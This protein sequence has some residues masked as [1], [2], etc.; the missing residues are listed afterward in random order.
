[1]GRNDRPADRADREKAAS[2][3][4]R[5]LIV[6]AAAGTGKT[7]L[8]VE[9]IV[10][11][12][13]AGMAQ[14]EEIVAITFTERA[15]A[16]LRARLQDKLGEEVAEASVSEAE[17]L[18]RA[19]HGLERMQ[20]S[21]IHAF[22]TS[23]LKERPVEAG[24]DPNFGVADELMASL[25]SEDTWDEWI[26]RKM[27]GDDPV[28][29]RTLALGI[30]PDRMLDKMHELAMTISE[31]RDVA[32]LLP[33]VKPSGKCVDDFLKAFKKTA[34]GLAEA[35]RFCR[36]PDDAAL[37]L[38]GDLVKHARDL[39]TIEGDERLHT[40]VFGMA[41][42]S[43]GRLG[44]AGNWISKDHLAEVRE[45]IGALKK[46]HKALK[47]LLAHNA[48]A[49]LSA[50]LLDYVDSYTAAK[51]SQGLLDFHDLLL[52]ARDL[53]KH[54]SHVRDY[55]SARYRYILVDEFQDTDPLQA[56]IIFYLAGARPG[57]TGKWHE[58]ETSPGKLFLVGDPKQSIY[59][60]RRADIEMY[61]AAKD[62]MGKSRSLSIHRNFR[63]SGSIIAA[64]NTIFQDLIEVPEDGNYQPEY[65]A[66]DFGRGED[67]LPA[68]HGAVLLYPPEG[69]SAVMNS[70][71]DRRRYESRS[72]AA[73]IKRV[74]VDAGWEVW[75]KA[76]RCLRPI[77][78]RDIAVLMRTQT[79]LEELEQALRL[80]GIDYR[81]IGGKRFFLCEEVQQLLAVLMAVDN[82]NDR[83]A[84]VAALRSPFFGV[85]D[86]AIFTFKAKGGDLSYLSDAAGPPLDGAFSL[87]RRLHSVR[88]EIGAD[89]LLHTLYA[90]TKA[91]VVFLLRPN[92]E[93]RVA[94]LLKVGDLA[95][96]LADRGVLTFRAFV[97]WLSERS[98]DEAEE[99]EAA[100]VETGDDFVRLLTIHKAK[101]L[102]FPMVILADLASK[103]NKSETFVVDRH[104]GEIA[105]RIGGKQLG[106][107]T[108]NYERLSDYE[109]LRR[110]AEERR[111]LSV[112]MTR[113]RDFVVIPA[114]YVTPGESPKK[115][116]ARP[117]SLFHYLARKIPFPGESG[118]GLLEGM[119]VFDSSKLD[120]EPSE[121]PTFRVQ[122]DPDAPETEVTEAMCERL[123]RW[124]N[125]RQDMIDS[126]AR[127]RN[128]RTATEEKEVI[129]ALGRSSGTLFGQLVHRLLER[130]D[131]ERPDL[132]AEVAEAEAPALGAASGMVEE[133]V[134]M[135][136]AALASDLVK[137][138]M[139]TDRYYK[140]VP[141]TF[142]EDGTLVEGVIDV[143][144]EKAGKIG[145]VDFKTDKVPKSKLAAKVGEYQSQLETYRRAVGA[146]C[147]TPPDEVILFFL[148]PM[149]V[150]EVSP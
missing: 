55:F 87:L 65:V 136:R 133:A 91:P 145:I 50:L 106:I 48:I 121:P 85:S 84:L 140:E 142:E 150:V 61:A 19:L 41:I 120:L 9:R 104:S 92:G 99:A 40:Y 139:E 78:L 95:R 16:E 135:V 11:L 54:H 96:A 35:G 22:C 116:D 98:E 58:L 94:N 31:N 7:T 114:Y 129:P 88:N 107:Q 53:L 57:R 20:V 72:I 23:I 134:E 76:A 44:N 10:N 60:F 17:G 149:E 102:E 4:S 47:S 130:V 124:R 3:L 8:L 6:E 30:P 118:G 137:R 13:K 34:A 119:R 67:T 144:F 111:L 38:I 12:L 51:A 37:C 74:V 29:R 148:H 127:G 108:S 112:A 66:L 110:E 2:D 113:A 71:D 81:V 21:T 109:D 97:R 64:V 46:K 69:A 18:V 43:V 90:E 24:V 70:T 32:E 123:E 5:S 42:P 75:D 68:S 131:W 117:R 52:F 125:R 36:K 128:L 62:A 147:G 146:A 82:P 56:E 132:L 28:L 103:R 138:I 14:P 93:Q 33:A 45:Q 25:I 141:F 73:F 100:T 143:V 80:Y 79:G 1:M 39:E 63:C 126:F 115:S 26:A 15:A 101:G 86:E 59:R 83:V 77:E 105:I 27:D 122:L 49:S 89:T